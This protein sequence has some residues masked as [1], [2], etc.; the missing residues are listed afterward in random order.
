MQSHARIQTV[1]RLRPQ[2]QR[3]VVER[4]EREAWT[5]YAEGSGEAPNYPADG[6]G[7]RFCQL[8]FNVIVRDR[9]GGKRILG[10]NSRSIGEESAVLL[11]REQLPLFEVVQ[12]QLE[13][14]NERPWVRAKVVD[15]RQTLGGFLVDVEYMIDD[16]R[17]A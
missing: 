10:V 13:D 11:S 16:Q 1:T 4:T 2:D 14:G 9:F 5:E 15:N 6:W 12:I 17:A 8:P 3:D 7:Q